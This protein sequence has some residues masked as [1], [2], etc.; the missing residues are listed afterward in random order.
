MTQMIRRYDQERE[1]RVQESRAL[2]PGMQPAEGPAL[3]RQK[4]YTGQAGAESATPESVRARVAG[5][6]AR[7]AAV[8][9]LAS[10]EEFFFRAMQDTRRDDIARVYNAYSP[11]EKA[12]FATALA[13]RGI[14]DKQK[15]H[16]PSKRKHVDEKLRGEIMADATESLRMNNSSGAQAQERE[17]GGKVYTLAANAMLSAQISDADETTLS[18]RDTLYDIKLLNRA[19]KFVREANVEAGRRDVEEAERQGGA[20]NDQLAGGYMDQRT[21]H[22]HKDVTQGQKIE[23]IQVTS[24]EAFTEFYKSLRKENSKNIAAFEALPEEEKR[25][26]VW[27]L[28]N[29]SKVVKSVGALRKNARHDDS[30]RQAAKQDISE[31]GD[32]A[33]GTSEYRRAALM[34]L[35]EEGRYYKTKVAYNQPI[36]RDAMHFVRATQMVRVTKLRKQHEAAAKGDQDLSG[37][38]KWSATNAIDVERAKMRIAADKVKDLDSFEVF[39]QSGLEKS[40]QLSFWEQYQALESQQKMLFIQGLSHRSTIEGKSDRSRVGVIQRIG[41]KT[42]KYSVND[43]AL[44]N[45][46]VIRYIQDKRGLTGQESEEEQ[47]ARFGKMVEDERDQSGKVTAKGDAWRAAVNLVSKDT[48]QLLGNKGY[49]IDV[50]MVQRALNLVRY[51]EKQM[52][53]IEEHHGGATGKGYGSEGQALR[54]QFAGGSEKHK[55]KVSE[56]EYQAV[57]M[58]SRDSINAAR[59]VSD[60][61]T[62]ETFFFQQMEADDNTRLSERYSQLTD[63]QKSLFIWGLAHRDAISRGRDENVIGLFSISALHHGYYDREARDR[64]KDEYARVGKRRLEGHAD[65]QVSELQNLD[66]SAYTAAALAILSR[67]GRRSNELAKL[68]HDKVS[69]ERLIERAF[70]LIEVAEKKRLSAEKKKRNEILEQAGM[71]GEITRRGTAE[72]QRAA[73]EAK[74]L[75][76]FAQFLSK[77]VTPTRLEKYVALREDQKNLFIKALANRDALDKKNRQR[78]NE[79]KRKDL[80]LQ[81]Q[82]ANIAERTEE[83]SRS[84]QQRAMIEGAKPT[85]QEIRLAAYNVLSSQGRAL[86]KRRFLGIKFGAAD[87]KLLDRAFRL[88]KETDA[89]LDTR[90]KAEDRETIMRTYGIT[91]LNHR[92]RQPL[93]Q[94]ADEIRTIEDFTAFFEAQMEEKG[95][96]RFL[97]LFNSYGP[98]MKRLFIAAVASYS[99]NFAKLPIQDQRLQLFHAKD[100]DTIYRAAAYRLLEH[101]KGNSPA[102]H[103]AVDRVNEHIEFRFQQQSGRPGGQTDRQKF[104]EEKQFMSPIQMEHRTEFESPILGGEAEHTGRSFARRKIGETMDNADRGIREG[105]ASYTDSLRT[106]LQ[107]TNGTG[108]GN[109]FR[110]AAVY[111][112][113]LYWFRSRDRVDTEAEGA[114]AAR[115]VNSREGFESYVGYHARQNERMSVYNA[116]KKLDEKDFTLLIAALGK[117]KVLDQSYEEGA[118]FESQDEEGRTEL[119][120]QYVAGTLSLGDRAYKDATV[121][122]TTTR[123]LSGEDNRSRYVQHEV[124]STVVDWNL[125]EEGLAFVQFIAHD[126][127]RMQERREKDQRTDEGGPG[128]FRTGEEEGEGGPLD[129]AMEAKGYLQS[130]Y[131]IYKQS[132]KIATHTGMERD[133]VKELVEKLPT[134]SGEVKKLLGELK[135]DS[136]IFSVSGIKD[137]ISQVTASEAYNILK[138]GGGA[139]ISLVKETKKTIENVVQLG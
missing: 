125:L 19:V 100:R 74:D 77:T 57:S 1:R 35:S 131:K 82:G 87:N 94:Q 29:P 43:E 25:M 24:M 37:A 139:V 52:R 66:A 3:E 118:S 31:K 134:S 129:T 11:T 97:Y 14:L 137:F 76:S 107:N 102:L 34:L 109:A 2:M 133:N 33:V 115:I 61:A 135:V 53:K 7:A 113:P 49:F 85:A 17:A 117:R 106:R 103:Y 58:A 27:A 28:A 123:A 67:E 112:N 121:A 104:A 36:I 73:D 86:G 12:F 68:H 81:A 48:Q 130:G 84:G 111:A 26:F 18:K 55:R 98:E 132:K 6:K 41:N 89:Q 99:E 30:L 91:K 42:R 120:N 23:A 32:V 13:N 78:V 9:D 56:A 21:V 50:G 70:H 90:L 16:A 138:N 126:E 62:F 71:E 47:R 51:A 20:V 128:T 92:A 83:G 95:K 39:L 88:I 72:I 10:F 40:K 96:Q 46:M 54:Q 122:L 4:R 8:H 22:F 60:R 127:V 75:P 65:E 119:L 79:R 63:E 93:R 5:P 38:A 69:D 114:Q 44:R 80:S 45:Q 105:Y 136:D 59:Q 110:R 116:I 124:R 15:K 108:V 101:I 64:M